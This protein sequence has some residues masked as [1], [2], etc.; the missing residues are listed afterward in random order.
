V[1]STAEG[2][3]AA[4]TKNGTAFILDKTTIQHSLAL[5]REWQGLANGV[6]R[7]YRNLQA[8]DKIFA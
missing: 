5:I 2:F 4:Y 6:G 7:L 3:G 1:A 8:C